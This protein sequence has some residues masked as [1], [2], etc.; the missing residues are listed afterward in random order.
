[1]SLKKRNTNLVLLITIIFSLSFPTLT[2]A[3]PS[4]TTTRLAGFDRYETASQ[5][6][7]SG[8]AQ[9]DYAILA[10]GENYPDALSAAPLAKKYNAPI[11]LTTSKS[12]PNTTKQ[13]LIDL[14]VKNVIIIG[15]T[16]VILASVESELQSMGLNTTRIFGN[17][18][19]ETSIKVAQQ[20]T[21]TPSTLFVVTGEDYPDALSVASIASIKQIP[22]ILVPNDSMPASV[23][24]YLAVIN[25]SKTYVIGYSDIISDKVCNQFPN[26]ERILGSD[27]YARNIAVNQMFNSNFKS[28]NI[29]VATGEG[30]A[31]ALTG[32][33]Y[34]AKISEPIILINNDSPTNTK[35]YYQQRLSKASNVYTF[36]G[37]GII[38]DNVIQDLNLYNTAN[39]DTALP[40]ELKLSK[41]STTICVGG[42]ETIVATSS[43]TGNVTWMSSN[44]AVATVSL[45]NVIGLSEGTAVI[46]ATTTDGSKKATCAITVSNSNVNG[47]GTGTGI[48]ITLS[49]LMKIGINTATFKYRILDKTG[50]DITQT[51]PVSQI[52]T[53]TSINA[54]ISLS[55]S[56]GIGTITY[57]SPSDLDKPIVITLCDLTTGINVSL[58]ST[59]T[60]DTGT[61]S[62]SS[63][64]NPISSANPSET[65]STHADSK[66]NKITIYSTSLAVA[67]GGVGY[68]TYKVQDQYGN[69]ISSSS[70]S[71][72]VV[73]KNDI[74]QVKARNGLLTLTPNTGTNPQALSLIVITA[75]DSVTGVSTSATLT[76]VPF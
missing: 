5:I 44:P 16:G 14:Q 65:S 51:V 19:Y 40:N 76:V 66:V 52:A 10:F 61:S 24:N 3:N 69:D 67:K 42:I 60:S 8:W 74:Y 39:G 46:T 49:N 20:I 72:N 23:K 70:L 73:F 25:V 56:E 53:A 7:K 71:N 4:P 28:D 33:A 55:P 31:D 45:G 22:I 59:S 29:C 68:A 21:T 11:L 63:T 12:L 36:G 62:S 9:S 50:T 37:T 26:T 6:A 58:S 41:T 38:S 43:D 15:G 57:N 2:F 18:K 47:I 1:M 64:T 48:T 35:D 75:Y 30:F 54:A 13:T 27:K 17:D 32:T 34:S